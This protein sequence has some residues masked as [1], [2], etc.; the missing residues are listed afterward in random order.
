MRHDLR[1]CPYPDLAHLARVRTDEPLNSD[2]E[3]AVLSV[4]SH[5]LRSGGPDC[6]Y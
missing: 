3:H 2:E 6:Q 4:L 1:S 5:V